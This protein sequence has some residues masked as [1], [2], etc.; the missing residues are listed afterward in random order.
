MRGGPTLSSVRGFFFGH[1]KSYFMGSITIFTDKITVFDENHL[2]YLRGSRQCSKT[3]FSIKVIV[4]V[5]ISKDMETFQYLQVANIPLLFLRFL[6][7][8]SII[9]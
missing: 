7:T 6:S 5:A 4:H 1:V 9:R 3:V 2:I 8:S